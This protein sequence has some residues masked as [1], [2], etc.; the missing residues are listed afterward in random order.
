LSATFFEFNSSLLLEYGC[1]Y[2]K[3]YEIDVSNNKNKIKNT[4]AAKTDFS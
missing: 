4:V 2:I 1:K 3:S